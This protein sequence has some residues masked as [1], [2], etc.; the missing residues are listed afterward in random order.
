MRTP[1]VT[2][3]S[4]RAMNFECTNTCRYAK[5]FERLRSWQEHRICWCEA[6]KLHVNHQVE[7]ISSDDEAVFRL[8]TGTFSH[9]QHVRQTY[10]DE[11]QR[12]SIAESSEYDHLFIDKPG[13]DSEVAYFASS[14]SRIIAIFLT[15]PMPDPPSPF[16]LNPEIAIQYHFTVSAARKDGPKPWNWLMQALSDV[17]WGRSSASLHVKE[18]AHDF[19][20]NL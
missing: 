17:I 10:Y 15:Y 8:L 14:D 11:L 2:G 9:F 1:N 16:P 7:S 13:L 20:A 18:T 6:R 5:C 3:L 4:E 12:G 19:R